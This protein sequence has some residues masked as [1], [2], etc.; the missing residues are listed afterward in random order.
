MVHSIR[1]VK[2]INQVV[3]RKFSNVYIIRL[4]RVEVYLKSWGSRWRGRYKGEVS[5]REVIVKIKMRN[6]ECNKKYWQKN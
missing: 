2:R 1:E 6:V 4:R 5:K 3:N